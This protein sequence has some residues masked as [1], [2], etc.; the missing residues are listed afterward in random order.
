MIGPSRSADAGRDALPRVRR[1]MSRRFF[2]LLLR[3]RCCAI[4]AEALSHQLL[5]SL[6]QILGLVLVVVLRPRC[7]GVFCSEK[8]PLVPQLFCSVIHDFPY[9]LRSVRHSDGT[10][11]SSGKSRLTA[12]I[13]VNAKRRSKACD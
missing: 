13:E 12:C 2:L 4:G 10:D 7:A 6:T 5:L 8:S 1:C 3:M 11:P 9:L